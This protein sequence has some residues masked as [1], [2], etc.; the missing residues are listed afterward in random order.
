M[1]NNKILF[2]ESESI[3]SCID[4]IM[5][6]I[7]YIR[8]VYTL[9][10]FLI[11]MSFYLYENKQ[12]TSIYNKKPFPNKKKTMFIFSVKKFTFGMKASRRQKG[13]GWNVHYIDVLCVEYPGILFQI[14]CCVLCISLHSLT[15]FLCTSEVPDFR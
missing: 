8:F 6:Y 3:V 13:L 14:G 10:H 7:K 1:F 5:L 12:K 2:I 9:L 4:Y 11:H 15:H